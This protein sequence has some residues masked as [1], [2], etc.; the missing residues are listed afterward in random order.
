MER[1]YGKQVTIVFD[2]YQHGSS[3]KDPTRQWHKISRVGP[4]VKF[5]SSAAIIKSQE[6]H[7]SIKWF[8]QE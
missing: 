4:Q 3:T 5:Q 8:K 2:G 6:G 7:F 1:H